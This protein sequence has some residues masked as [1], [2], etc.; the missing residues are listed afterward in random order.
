MI[1]AILLT[2]EPVKTWE[3]IVL[4]KKSFGFVLLVFLTPLILLS[5]GCEMAGLI[6]FGRKMDY[7]P[8]IQLPQKIQ[9]TYGVTQLVFSFAVVFIGARLIKALAETFHSR[10][11]YT[12]A[13]TLVAYGLSPLFTASLPQFFFYRHRNPWASFGIGIAICLM[14]LYHGVRARRCGPDP[15]NAFG[16]Y[17][18]S[19][20]LPGRRGWPRPLCFDNPSPRRKNT[21]F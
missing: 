1:K 13:F 9:I 10:N 12:Q 11:T 5:V 14:A 20:I 4:V 16:I 18:M 6:Y 3:R 8:A 7:G 2:F 15:P 21:F 19:A 17:L